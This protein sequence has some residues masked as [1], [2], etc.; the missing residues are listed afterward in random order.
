M[1]GRRGPGPTVLGYHWCVPGCGKSC[2]LATLREEEKLHCVITGAAGFIGSHLTHRC[3]AEGY[4]VIGIDSLTDYYDPALKRK[5]LAFL[6]QHTSW[7]FVE[8]DILNID[9]PQHFASA[10][11]VFHLAA[12]PGVRGSWGS[13]FHRY[14]E[15]NV[16]STQAV[17]EAARNTAIRRLVFASSSSVY[18]DAKSFPTP[19]DE[20]L[21]PVSPY[22]ATKVIGEHLCRQYW[23]SYGVPTVMLRYFTVFGPRQRPDMA[24][25][26]LI[27]AALRGEE[28][29]IYGDGNQGRDFT[30]VLDAVEATLAAATTG[31]PGTPYNIGGGARITINDVLD[32]LSSALDTDLIVSRVAPQLGDARD[33]AADTGRARRDLGYSPKT[34]VQ[35][36]IRLQIAEI[37]RSLDHAW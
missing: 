22:G 34:T 13:G 26:R 3:L 27:S 20:E 12:Q 2:S 1:D 29:V 25:H 5:N 32:D 9:L 33:T 19:E 17:L 11:V 23:H 24:F 16:L 21:C 35:E 31:A 8:G 30:F 4:S 10:D 14:V 15:R 37:R 36:G 18:G 7:S 28:I 6:E